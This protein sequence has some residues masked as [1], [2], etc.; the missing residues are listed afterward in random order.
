[1][2]YNYV[3]NNQY[4]Y[5]LCDEMSFLKNNGNI[6]EPINIEKGT[7][8]LYNDDS[9]VHLA[10]NTYVQSYEYTTANDTIT[11]A[12]LNNVYNA[13]YAVNVVLH[14]P[15]ITTTNAECTLTANGTPY[16]HSFDGV[17]KVFTTFEGKLFNQTNCTIT[18]TS[19]AP[20]DILVRV[21]YD[22]II[23]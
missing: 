23:S 4:K 9:L 3:F 1:M 21:T 6:V 16:T 17:P 13:I 14:N 10:D 18:F 2:Q 11:I 12:S 19:N 20:A 7:Y 15:D 8:Y 22:K 5:T